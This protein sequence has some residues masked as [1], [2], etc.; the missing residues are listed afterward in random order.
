MELHGIDKAGY[1]TLV[2]D[3]VAKLTGTPARSFKD[4]AKEHAAR[5]SV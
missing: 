1:A 4:F 5:W 2:N 3:E